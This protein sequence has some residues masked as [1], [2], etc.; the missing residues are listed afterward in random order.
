M[1]AYWTSSTRVGGHDHSDEDGGPDAPGSKAWCVKMEDG[2]TV[3]H[4]KYHLGGGHV[5][6]VLPVLIASAEAGGPAPA[7]TTGQDLCWPTDFAFDLDH[8]V[9]LE[10]ISC[11]H[12]DAVGQDAVLQPGVHYSASRFTDNNDGTVLDT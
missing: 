1:G 7:A 9:E 3:G 6:A 8:S 2:T 10:P 4:F 12:P 11:T 5:A